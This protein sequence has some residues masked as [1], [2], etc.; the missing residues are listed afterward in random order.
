MKIYRG[1]DDDDDDGQRVLCYYDSE[2][3]DGFD[4]STTPL[5]ST[6]WFNSIITKVG[7]LLN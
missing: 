2:S 5:Q 7:Y 3:V 6:Q 1:D 4:G